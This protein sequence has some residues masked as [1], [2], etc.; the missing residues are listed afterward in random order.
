MVEKRIASVRIHVDRAMERIK[1]LH[2]FDR[3][4]PATVTDVAEQMFFV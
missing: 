2:I 1:N 3:V 4:I